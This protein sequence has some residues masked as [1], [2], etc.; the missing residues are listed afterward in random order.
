VETDGLSPDQVVQRVR[1]LVESQPG[2]GG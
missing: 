2:E 1:R